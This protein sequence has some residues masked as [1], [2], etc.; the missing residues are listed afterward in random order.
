M[1]TSPIPAPILYSDFRINFGTH[2]VTEDILI[3]NNVDAVIQSI[4]NIVYT[5]PGERPRKPE[6]GSGV[7]ALLFEPVTAITSDRI[8]N[9]ITNAIKNFEPRCN[10]LGVTVNVLPDQNAYAATIT[11]SVINLE[12]PVQFSVFLNRVR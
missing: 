6:F 5:R 2:P 10:L 1:A 8:L 11:F 7:L 4:K 12:R 3:Q 9:A